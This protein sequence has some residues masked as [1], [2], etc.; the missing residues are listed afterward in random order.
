MRK[1]YLAALMS[2]VSCAALARPPKP[3]IVRFGDSLSD[4]GNIANSM[5]RPGLF[6]G[7]YSTGPLG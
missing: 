3:A 4:N 6:P 5:D 7:R 2:A 1:A